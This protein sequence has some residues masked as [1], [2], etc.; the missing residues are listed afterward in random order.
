MRWTLPLLALALAGT[1]T[2]QKNTALYTEL[3]AMQ[4]ADQEV[5]TRLIDVMKSGQQPSPA[6]RQELARIDRG[7]AARMWQIINQY[8][9]PTR[10]EVGHEGASAAWLIVQHADH[11][12][13]L[14][15]KALALMEPLVKKGEADGSDFALLFDRVRVNSGQKQR[16]GTQ[17]HEVNGMYEMKPLENPKKVDQWRKEVGLPPLE[18]YF[19][20]IE[21]MYGKKVRRK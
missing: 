17:M 5:R 12:V 16:Y 11:D 2:A 9:W 6:L 10:T 19:K 1:A 3:L 7:H 14:Q 18:D 15:K 20:L 13:K 21:V 4:M 8:G